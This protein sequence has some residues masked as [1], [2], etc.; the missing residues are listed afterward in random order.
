MAPAGIAAS[1]KKSNGS[2][3]H[4]EGRVRRDRTEM[5]FGFSERTRFE[6]LDQSGHRAIHTML[7]WG[8]KWDNMTIG[9][10]WH[11]VGRRRPLSVLETLRVR[12]QNVEDKGILKRDFLEIIITS[13][14]TAMTGPHVGFE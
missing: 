1:N 7:L 8:T 6:A 14:G 10:T 2:V 5:G 13:G 4:K 9:R 12:I 11:P 3:W